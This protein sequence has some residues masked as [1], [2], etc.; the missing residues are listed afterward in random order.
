MKLNDSLSIVIR[1]AILILLSLGNLK[2]FYLIFTPLTVYPAFWVLKWL[3]GAQL[4]IGNQIFFSGNYIELVNAC[5]A[6]SAYY[7]LIILNLTTPMQIRKRIKSILLILVGFLMINIIRIVV[8]AIILRQSFSFFEATHIWTWY[9]GGTIIVIL[10]W[11]ANAFILGIKGIPVYT[12]F[13]GIYKDIK[14]KKKK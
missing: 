14:R 6:G 7:L 2:I 12:D 11:F 4:L 13:R 8:F 3:Y 1:Y 10:L 5:I 9:L